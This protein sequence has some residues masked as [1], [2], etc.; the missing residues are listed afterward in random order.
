M[1]TTTNIKMSANTATQNT[2]N[3]TDEGT[4]NH[5][6]NNIKMVARISNVF[7]MEN[8]SKLV[9][10]AAVGL[11]LTIGLGMHSQA[12]ADNPSV[13]NVGS[14]LASNYNDDFSL[15]YGTPNTPAK[16]I[17]GATNNMANDDF[18]LVYGTPDAPAKLRI[19]AA[20]N[21]VN[22]DFSLVYGTPDA[23][24]KLRIGAA[25][26]MVNDDFSLVY[27]TP[28]APAKLQA[29]SSGLVYNDDF[30]MIYGIPDIIA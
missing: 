6:N 10:T 7:R 13:T 17:I 28:D 26:N 16:V 1:T 4:T 9:T 8:I 19:G 11:A 15:V 27:G 12:S 22:D 24:A 2:N 3:M 25:N 5:T 14:Q 23:P 18:S 29:E 30:S 20:N 21:M